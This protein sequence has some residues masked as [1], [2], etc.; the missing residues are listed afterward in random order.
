M[1]SSQKLAGFLAG[2]SI[3]CIWASW[4]IITRLGLETDL[5]IYDLM[6]L[7]L[8]VA[9]LLIAPVIYSSE[10]RVKTPVF[11]RVAFS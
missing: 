5:Q 9:T 3:T 6:A 7:R 4:T 8:L 2:I 11:R 1:F 10:I